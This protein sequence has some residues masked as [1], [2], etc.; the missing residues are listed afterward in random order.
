MSVFRP[1]AEAAA[2]DD[3]P[4]AGAEAAQAEA[5]A[6]GALSFGAL[7]DSASFMLRLAQLAAFA[8]VFAL[9]AHD[10]LRLSERT[11]LEMIAANPGVRQGAIADVLRIKWPHM[12]RLVRGLE[13]RGL[14]RRDV[15]PNDRRS[16]YLR[17]TPAGARML[18]GLRPRLRTNDAGAMAMLDAAER[19]ELI[20]LCRK[21]AGLPPLPPSQG[22]QA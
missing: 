21:V 9:D 13:D 15:P 10:D 12:T 11:V 4:E 2:P 22:P 16:V 7:E 3:A 8:G 20:R 18:E 1:L 17:L 5:R 6:D 14:V 19:A